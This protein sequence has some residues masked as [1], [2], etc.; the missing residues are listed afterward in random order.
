MFTVDENHCSLRP[1]ASASPANL[2]ARLIG[3]VEMSPAG[4]SSRRQAPVRGCDR[5]KPSQAG[6]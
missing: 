3:G 2:A 1:S 4:F 6:R 5:S